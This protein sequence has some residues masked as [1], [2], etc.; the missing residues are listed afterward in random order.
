MTAIKMG[1]TIEEA[2]ECTPQLLLFFTTKICNSLKNIIMFLHY[3]PEIRIVSGFWADFS[4]VFRTSVVQYL[5]VI[6]TKGSDTFVPRLH[7]E[8]PRC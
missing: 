6:A 1:L 3:L 5:V 8:N 4:C 7:G 2:A